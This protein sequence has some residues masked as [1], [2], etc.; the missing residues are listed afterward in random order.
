MK[1][2][3][4]PSLGED[5]IQQ[6]EENLAGSYNDML[7]MIVNHFFVDGAQHICMAMGV[8]HP[9]KDVLINKEPRP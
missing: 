7:Y 4:C 1:V 5:H 2:S 9:Y 8:C 6:C 3:Y